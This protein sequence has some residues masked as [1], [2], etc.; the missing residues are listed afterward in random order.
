MSQVTT[1]PAAS[2]NSVQTSASLSSGS[3]A[4][5]KPAMDLSADALNQIENMMK[6]VIKPEMKEVK[7]QLDNKMKEVKRQMKEVKTQLDHEMNEVKRDM[8]EVKRH[9]NEVKTQLDRLEQRTGILVEEKARM[10][11]SR[12]FGSDFSER[13]LIKSI[14]EVVKLI[15]KA[16][17][18]RLPKD[19]GMNA[20]I[21]AVDLVLRVLKTLLIAFVKSVVLSISIASTDEV[22]DHS[23]FEGAK[24]QIETAEHL[25]QG[26]TPDSAK[27]CGL[28][29][30]AIK[31]MSTE[32]LVGGHEE[33]TGQAH[34]QIQE[35][36]RTHQNRISGKEWSH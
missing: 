34:W 15:S 11:A 19:H 33:Q 2:H 32:T 29:I 13:F 27:I 25:S 21:D 10:M 12:M 4:S 30:D 36:T 6:R 26:K 3:P 20:R 22:F 31:K 28:L 5:R 8:N 23:E 1:T 9:M 35:K 16:N 14:H 24:S 7:T 18:K 17:D